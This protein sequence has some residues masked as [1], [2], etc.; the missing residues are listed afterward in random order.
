MLKRDLLKI[1]LNVLG[2]DVKYKNAVIFNQFQKSKWLNWYKSN[3]LLIGNP[4]IFKLAMRL[5]DQHNEII[6]IGSSVVYAESSPPPV[7]T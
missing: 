6:E 4:I 7:Y 2:S 5:R 1:T 3:F